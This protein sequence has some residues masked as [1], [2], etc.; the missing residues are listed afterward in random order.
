MPPP[1]RRITDNSQIKKRSIVVA[2][3][4]TSISVEDEFWEALNRLAKLNQETIQS[5]VSNID[6]GRES[7]NLSSAVRLAILREARAGKLPLV[8]AEQSDRLD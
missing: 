8:T 7:G 4:R 2:G 6:S 5:F 1:N 3:H